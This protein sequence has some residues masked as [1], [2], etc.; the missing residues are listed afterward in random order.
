MVKEKRVTLSLSKGMKQTEL[1]WIPEDWE[2]VRLKYVLS[3]YKLGGN[4]QTTDVRNENPLIKMG[5]IE[6]GRINLS[7]LEYITSE[8]NSSD[9]LKFGDVL[10]NTR[11][12]LD[13]VGKVAIWTNELSRA[14]YNSNLLRFHFK[15]DL[16]GSNFFVNAIFNDKKTLKQLADIATGTTSVAAIYTKDLL[17]IQIPL[18]SLPEQQAIATALSDCDAWID[19]LEKVIAKKQLIKQAAMQELLTPKEGW[20][21]KNLGEIGSCL[22]GVSYSGE[23]DLFNSDNEYSVK[24]LRSNNVFN[25]KV[26][27]ENVQNVNKQRVKEQQI[28]R[29]NDVLICMANGSKDLVGKAGYCNKIFD[30]GKF[31]FGA[32]MGIFR[33]NCSIVHPYFLYNN[34]LTR[35]YRNYIDLLLSGSSINNLKPSDIEQITINIPS[36][37]EQTRIATILSD[38]DAEIEALERKL[39]KARQIKQGMMQE[40]LT[41][42][43]RLV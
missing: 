25:S 38:M 23:S 1:G 6:R 8:L 41:G 16:I 32:F 19:S 20:E 4:Y 10:F 29:R 36:Y 18:P 37:S 3:S 11:N 7:K 42:R 21:V 24:L 17:E 9:L 5:N 31:T 33:L 27:F 15:K 13:L 30:T 43:V 39:H 34:F 26:I 35:N 14:F 22:R 40:L 28:I 2:V 12:T